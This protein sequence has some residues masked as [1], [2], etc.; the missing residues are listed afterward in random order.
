MGGKW[1]F[2]KL[3]QERFH[4][5][6][7]CHAVHVWLAQRLGVLGLS[8]LK[9]DENAHLYLSRGE[10]EAQGDCGS[11]RLDKLQSR[12][13]L[14]GGGGVPCRS[15]VKLLLLARLGRGSGS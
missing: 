5:A 15:C 2:G 9:M 12:A 8:S 14:Q 3:L 11:A 1:C 13:V 10:L 4:C 7:I 6:C